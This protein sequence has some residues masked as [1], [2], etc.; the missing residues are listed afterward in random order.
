MIE[1]YDV[2]FFR[3]NGY[4]FFIGMKVFIYYVCRIC[5]LE[6]C[7]Y[8]VF[9]R[10]VVFNADMNLGMMCLEYVIGNYYVS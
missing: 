3:F 6:C 9:R 7:V 4:G 10:L 2:C 5:G 8:C 1:Y